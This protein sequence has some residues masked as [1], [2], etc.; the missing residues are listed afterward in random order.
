MID[1]LTYRGGRDREIWTQPLVPVGPTTVAPVFAAVV[2]PNLRRLVDIWMR[3]AG[4]DMAKR[5]E[6]FEAHIRALVQQA[7]SE[8][9]LLSGHAMSIAQD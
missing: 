9:K 6:A 3:R 2:D 8:S 4:I 1:F 7:I 5:G